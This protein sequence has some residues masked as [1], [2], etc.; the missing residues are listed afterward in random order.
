M[1]K[2]HRILWAEALFV[3]VVYILHPR[4]FGWI[5][6]DVLFLILAFL[7]LLAMHEESQA[8]NKTVPK[9]AMALISLTFI[10]F[11]AVPF[12]PMLDG[13]T[14]SIGGSSDSG[15]TLSLLGIF[16]GIFGYLN[17]QEHTYGTLDDETSEK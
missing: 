9:L 12:F 11:Y 3:G 6:S 13:L 4:L 14:G 1:I 17:W 7:V 16:S 8:A 2:K 10:L 5:D 15:N